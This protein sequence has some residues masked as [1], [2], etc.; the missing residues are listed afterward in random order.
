MNIKLINPYNNN[1]VNLY[2]I[3][4]KKEIDEALVRARDASYIWSKVDLE[5]RIKIMNNLLKDLIKE[6]DNIAN[7]ISQ[8][9]GKPLSQS[10]IEMEKGF[11]YYEYYLENIKRYVG[12]KINYEDENQ[13]DIIR[14]EP[15]GVAAVILSWN[16]P[17]TLFIW[18]VIP[19]LLVGNSVIV[20]NSSS[21]VS[22]S[23]YLAKIVYNS[24]LPTGVFNNIVGKYRQAEYLLTKHIDLI[25]FTGGVDTGR[26]LYKIAS[27][28]MITTVIEMGG[29][30]PA[31]IFD[32]YP[33]Q[34]AVKKIVEKRFNNAGQVCNAV[35]RIIVKES[36]K[37]EFIANLLS[38][39]K[40][41]KVGNP[42]NQKTDIG[43]LITKKQLTLLEEQVSDAIDKGGKIEIGGKKP[44][45]LKGNFYEPTVITNVTKDMRV[46]QEE[47][48]G[49]VLPIMTFRIDQ[50]AIDL[51]NE[52]SYG[53][54]T[55]ILTGDL[56]K[57]RRIA[58]TLDCGMVDINDGKCSKS[59]NP[60]GGT[61]KSSIGRV[62]GEWGFREL[63]NTKVISTS[64]L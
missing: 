60:F 2:K 43:P 54:G 62:H 27:K 7:L 46:W 18:H 26:H 32:D 55:L 6:K 16:F 10:Q 25:C 37:D 34:K 15:K 40:K 49:P 14:Y 64:K 5:E 57:A 48:F 50:Q 58:N 9:I 36:I 35:K 23:N 41:L 13:K 21:C 33:I 39:V 63:T 4:T 47:T 20:K 1:I 61:K 59:C 17:F 52:S 29:S 28:K 31:V 22:T 30:N 51:V 38:K 44:K 11:K 24:K 12:D 42:F 56:K 45:G 3:S 8:E 53:M 19:N